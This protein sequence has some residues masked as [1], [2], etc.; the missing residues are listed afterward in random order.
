M[1][2]LRPHHVLDIVT[3]YGAGVPFMPHDYGHAVHS[4]A[5]ALLADPELS[6]QFVVGADHICAPCK[7][8]VGGRCDDVLHQLDPPTPKQDYNDDLDRRL[9]AYLGIAEG[10]VMTF[11]EYL[12]IVHSHLDG[13][14]AICTHPREDPATRLDNLALG[15]RKLGL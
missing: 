13:I 1:M 9:L 10:D 6:L 7:H 3:Q 4:V 15:L 11:R 12:G 8:L 2:R 5:E 14:A